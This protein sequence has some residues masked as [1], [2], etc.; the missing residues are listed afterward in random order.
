MVVPAAG[1]DR[2][3]RIDCVISRIVLFGRDTKRCT[4]QAVV[5]RSAPKCPTIAKVERHGVARFSRQCSV[6][7]RRRSVLKHLKGAVCREEVVRRICRGVAQSNCVSVV[8]MQLGEFLNDIHGSPRDLTCS[9][10]RHIP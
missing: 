9:T 3:V 1:D 6:G 5:C 8:S 10:K 4:S 2:R 7:A